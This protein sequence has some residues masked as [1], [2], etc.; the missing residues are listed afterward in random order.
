MYKVKRLTV[1][2]LQLTNKELLKGILN[3]EKIDEKELNEYDVLCAEFL[4][5]VLRKTKN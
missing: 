5:A 1:K 2:D 4:K 3:V